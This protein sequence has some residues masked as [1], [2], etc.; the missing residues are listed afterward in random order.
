MTYQNLIEEFTSDF[1]REYGER[2]LRKI[3]DKVESSRSVR[4]ALNKLNELN[5]YP[6]S[7]DVVATVMNMPYFMFGKREL[8]AMG[9][10]AFLELWN[11]KL[12]NDNRFLDDLELALLFRRVLNQCG[13]ML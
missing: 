12:N 3:I 6:G 2:K 10:I 7:E 4:K 1:I 5:T 13:Q 8:V 9:S 11:N